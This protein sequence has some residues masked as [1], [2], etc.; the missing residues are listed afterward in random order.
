[1]GKLKNYDIGE[2]IS[3]PV[4][5]KEPEVPAILHD[6]LALPPEKADESTAYVPNI[7]E[8]EILPSFATQAHKLIEYCDQHAAIAKENLHHTAAASFKT[9]KA[10]I[11]GTLKTVG[12]YA[13]HKKVE[14]A[15]PTKTQAAPK[16]K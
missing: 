2:P 6:P 10:H 8:G 7:K 5:P 1:M 9:L 15:A 3:E 13:Y 11:E 14:E 16:K 12:K 4:E